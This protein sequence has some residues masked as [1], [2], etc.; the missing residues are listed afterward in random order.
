MV[1]AVLLILLIAPAAELYADPPV[2]AALSPWIDWVLAGEDQRA[3][4]LG[5]TGAGE[6]VCAWPGRLRLELDDAGGRF[7]QAWTLAA[8]EWV[9]VPGGSGQW[10]QQV[11]VNGAPAAVVERNGRPMAR[12]ASGEHR[13]SGHFAWPRRPDVLQV[14]AEVGLLS[15]SLNAVEIEQPRLDATGGLWLG[16]ERRPRQPQQEPDALSLEVT[17]RIEDSVPLRVQTRLLLEVSGQPRESLLGPIL[18]PGGRPLRLESPL[19]ARL[20]EQGAP[21]LQLQLRPGRWELTLESHHPGPAVSALR[22]PKQPSAP[23]STS[24]PNWPTQEVWV[25]AARPDLRRVELSGA[26]PIDPRQT[27]L[28]AQWQQLPAY[29]M[30][31]GETLRIEQLSR[32]AT[33]SDQI[34]LERVMRLDFDATGLSLRDRLS[35]ELRERRRIEV[36]PPLRLG[37]VSVDGEPRLITRLTTGSADQAER[38]G[39]EARGARLEL[40][41]DARI[42]SGPVG[43]HLELP[44]SGWALPLS[45]VSTQ[46]F[47]PPGWDLLAAAGVDNLPDSWLARWSLLDI[48]L[49]LIA[50]LAVTRLWGWP[51]GLLALL[52]LVLT[53]QE[54]GAPRWVWLHLIAAAA[55]VRLLPESARRAPPIS[56]QRDEPSG[57][58]SHAQGPPWLATGVRLYARLALLSLVLIAVPFLV[59]A[60]RDGLF[61]QLEQQRLGLVDSPTGWLT[62]MSAVDQ[63]G[64]RLHHQVE[65]SRV[66]SAPAE[67]GA[68]QASAPRLLPTLDP[69]ARLQTGAGVPEWSWRRFELSWSGPMPPDHRLHLWLLP[70]SAS[71]PLALLTLVL[72]PLL[73]LRLAD[74]RSSRQPTGTP[75]AP[76]SGKHAA[77]LGLLALAL[78]GGLW[79]SP[80]PSLAATAPAFQQHPPPVSQPMPELAAAPLTAHPAANSAGFPPASLLAELRQRLLAPPDCAPRC[81][82]IARLVLDAS[83][84][85]LR[86]LLAVD[87]VEA[88]ALPVP[89]ARNGWSPSRVELNG[90][91]L[92]R[93]LGLTNGDLA[94]SIPS[95]RHLL[96]LSG[97]LA[98][99]EQV[100]IPLPL[101][102]R[103]LET[104]IDPV[105]QLEGLGDDGVPG[106]QLRLVRQ[107]EAKGLA[108][109][110]EPDGASINDQNPGGGG[111]TSGSMS[112]SASA[113]ASDAA[114][115]DTQAPWPP[116]LKITR[117]LS[118]GLDWEL[119]TEVERRSPLGQ[120][121][122]LRVALIDGES[123]TTSGV[124]I[125]DA[126]VL[127][128]LPPGR[129]RMRWRSALRP[130]DRLALR[131]SSDPR[132]T[133]E[134]RLQV[135]PIWH[136][137]AQGVPAVQPR[138]GDARALPTYRPWPG[139]VLELSLSRPVGVAGPTLTL[140]RSRYRLQPGR[141]SSE[142]LLQLNLRSS[143][144]GRHRLLL[145]AGAEP[146]RLRVDGQSRPLLMQDNAV[147]LALVPG[148][149]RIE[150]SWLQPDGLSFVYQPAAVTLGVAGVNAETQVRL[151]AD[152]WLLWASGPGLGPAVQFWGLL[153]VIAVLALILARARL[154]PLGVGDWLLLGIGLSQVSIWVGALVVLWLFAL[155]L[156]RRLGEDALAPWRFNLMQIGL[157]LLSM[158][159]L[160]ALLLAVQQGL[161]GSPAMQVAGNGSSATELNWYLDRSGEQTAPVTVIS[162]PIW[163]Y[164]LLMLAWAL[165]LAWRLLDWLRWGWQGLVAPTPWRQ[166]RRQ[167][168]KR[169]ATEEGL[170]VDL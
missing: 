152:R 10:P 68:D 69:D 16:A 25:F 73:G 107:Q 130:V 17:R 20:M 4:A 164:R 18:L 90:Q 101:R 71:L 149:Q 39:V 125:R 168:L 103:L 27:R 6:R 21:L 127:V 88:I 165:W 13:L 151:G 140:D 75:T 76:T 11:S 14:P 67:V 102:P 1:A 100:A 123:V 142:A 105:W 111:T 158:A 32:G 72:V 29:L 91:P 64:S 36:E 134:W 146:T 34:Q 43:W 144:G 131:A 26:D 141:R 35:G 128:S 48:F 112:A 33:G 129:A 81:A 31:A 46:L 116:L 24:A 62:P 77:H 86:L 5:A 45:R 160:S 15:L 124:Q 51:W 55:L 28:P 118:F 53:W 89:G 166:S 56:Q 170:S 153:L 117:T 57:D 145:P 44:G 19:P 93:L 95:G 157:V 49:V 83:P 120:S 3:C 85:A 63:V 115:S 94:V 109:G 154:T 126:E 143:Q 156:R 99:V 80:S 92:D 137:R 138:D 148:S 23:A 167:A 87:A 7:E 163:I 66:K 121:V 84:R 139:E 96:L 50:A 41:A 30:R 42:D 122:S 155:G 47:L 70:A 162:A 12:L 52:T 114:R 97:S 113:P 106:D 159:A 136:L 82:E 58:A 65:S 60:M 9:P 104:S 132:L 108:A 78:I 59:T 161:L 147:D 135:S 38:E 169:K 8:A 2:P 133:E 119:I 110:D 40:S 74:R 150:L 22:L 79:L 98:G 54:P 37:Q 61:P